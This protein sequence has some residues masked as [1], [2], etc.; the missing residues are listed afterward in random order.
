MSSTTDA[1][2]TNQ[3][4]VGWLI[5]LLALIVLF[6]LGVQTWG[7]SIGLERIPWTFL[8]PVT[9][10]FAFVHSGVMLGWAR[11]ITLMALAVV[12]SFLFEYVGES[13]GAIFGPYHYTDLL[14]YKLFDKI[15]LIIPFAWYMMFYPSYV[16]TNILAEGS[17]VSSRGGWVWLIWISVLSALVMTAWDITMDPIMS[18]H[19]CGSDV[20]GCVPA[21]LEAANVGHPAW[22][23]D[24]GGVHFGVPLKNYRGWLITSFVVFFLYRWIEPRIGHQ[25]TA[26]GMSRLVAFLPVGVYGTMAMVDTWLG[27]PEIEDIHLISPFVMG[28]PF[29]AAAIHL[30]ANRTDLPLWPGSGPKAD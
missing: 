30:F 4:G 11:A 23:W 6:Y 16:V 21:T 15:P 7:I 24:E 14:G 10:L 8:V 18:W 17:P 2:G 27:Y 3:P 19:G 28:I 22:I 13:T 29:L 9:A 12:V 25:P 5:Y 20:G 1:T 26:G